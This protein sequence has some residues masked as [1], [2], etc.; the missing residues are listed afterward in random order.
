MDVLTMAACSP[1][2]S[3]GGR[4]TWGAVF[5]FLPLVWLVLNPSG[6]AA[7][8]VSRQEI[9]AA[10]IIKFI[11]YTQWP[12]GAFRGEGNQWF[13][14]AVLGKENYT[15]LFEPFRNRLFQDRKLR[16]IRSVDGREIKQAGDGTIQILVADQWE[17]HILIELLPLISGR[18][19]LTFG[20]FPGFTEKG[21]IVN[22]YQKPNNQIG[23]EVNMDAKERS[24]IKISSHLLR[25]AKKVFGK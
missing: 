10:F 2:P 16:I 15:G 4:S 12:D 25:M 21:G 11:K 1:L 17:E 24:G 9:Q 23:F 7:G 14:I 8:T 20:D 22:F 13:T 5:L 19:I 18:P 3:R 6:V